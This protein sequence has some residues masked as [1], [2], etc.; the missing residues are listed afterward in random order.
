MSKISKGTGVPF[1]VWRDKLPEE[2][3][4]KV[5]FLTLRNFYEDGLD[6]K[7]VIIKV[8]SDY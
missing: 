8:E 1:N 3:K 6:I 2:I 4:K 5:K 7:E